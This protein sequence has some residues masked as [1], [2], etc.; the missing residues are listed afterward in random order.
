MN[1]LTNPPGSGRGRAGEL[2]AALSAAGA[3]AAPEGAAPPY[4]PDPQPEPPVRLQWAFRAVERVVLAVEGAS[5]RALPDAW[6]PLLQSGAVANTLLIVACV[7]GVLLLF[8]YSP[9]VHLAH[10]SMRALEADFLGSL[11]R[12]A[13]RFSSDGCVAFAAWHALRLTAA[14]RFTGARWLAW[15]TG[16]F[17]V[18]LLWVVG[19]L[20]YW[21]V[22]DEPARQV[23][24]GT[25]RVLDVLPIFADPLS[26]E[27]V[28]D[29]T[30]NSLLFFIVFFAHMLIPLGMGIALWLHIARLARSNF[31]VSK[32]LGLWLLGATLVL[33]AVAPPLAGEAARMARVPGAFGYDAWFLWPLWLTDRMPGGP[34]FLLAATAGA[35]GFLVPWLFAKRRPKPATVVTSRC[36]GCEQCVKDC[37]Y[38]AIS[39]IPRNDGRSFPTQALV[40]PSRCV[41]CGICSGSCARG[42]SGL[43]HFEAL[44][45]RARIERWLESEPVGD[46]RHLAFLCHDAAG[47]DLV[48]DPQSGACAALRGYRVLKVPCAGWVHGITVDRALAR[49]APGVLIVGCAGTCRY[50]EGAQWAQERLLGK[51]EPSLPAHADRTRVRLLELDRTQT[52]ALLA[53]AEAFRGG[54]GPL[55]RARLPRYAGAALACGVGAAVVWGGQALSYRPPALD[56]S[57]LVLS[58][59]HPG[60]VDERCR[61]VTAE[62]NARRPVHMRREQ[63]CSR[64]RQ[65]VRV[66]VELEGQRLLD[67][68]YPAAGLWGDGP[69]IGLE[70]LAVPPGRHAVALKVGDSA[71]PEEWAFTAEREVE[72]VRGQSPAVIFDRGTGF[73]WRLDERP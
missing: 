63:E 18:A 2:E 48:V 35:V 58:F 14:R 73:V 55:R 39:M 53:A 40:D 16:L 21:L 65:P 61:P 17:A 41:G 70:R 24:L 64:G 37:P 66:R 47:H 19:W 7:T 69:S 20:G 43:P 60:R 29:Q 27:F 26:R 51:R 9:S 36:N 30:I 33:S 49:G 38:D 52:A 44:L 5:R 54:Q 32:T 1:A 42:G 68:Q 71:D 34:L 72:F 57:A 59:R 50:R 8:W 46:E 12:A 25:A 4:A 31:L 56:G 28:A 22:W 11:V 62:E 45:E 13:H 3:A 10:A 67:K 15:V 23:A 6:N